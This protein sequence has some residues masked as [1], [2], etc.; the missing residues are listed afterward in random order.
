M[1][2]VSGFDFTK[3]WGHSDIELD[4]E[5]NRPREFDEG[6]KIV[7]KDA[8]E[9]FGGSSW[10]WN[11]FEGTE[12][13]KRLF[14]GVKVFSFRGAAL[15]SDLSFGIRRKREPSYRQLTCNVSC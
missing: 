14:E 7:A 2:D 4:W 9:G 12:K 11:D 5:K 8:S 6:Y 1:E 3:F 10:D 13:R 15:V